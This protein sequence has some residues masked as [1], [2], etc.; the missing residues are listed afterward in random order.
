VLLNNLTTAEE[1]DDL[2]SYGRETLE[3]WGVSTTNTIPAAQIDAVVSLIAAL[4]SFFFIT[5]F[6]GHRKFPGQ[7]A[8]GKICPGNVGMELVKAIRVKT[9][10]LQ[11][12]TA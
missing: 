7:R 2:V 6:G 8:E 10:L 3:S 11:P 12:P 5:R 9:Q 4:K 1:G